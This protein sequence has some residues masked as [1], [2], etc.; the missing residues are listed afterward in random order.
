MICVL[1]NRKDFFFWH[2][3]IGAIVFR[4][5][6]KYW[7]C[8][9]HA[10]DEFGLDRYER[11]KAKKHKARR[12]KSSFPREIFD[13]ENSHPQSCDIIS[14]D[15]GF[16]ANASNVSALMENVVTPVN[17][18]RRRGPDDGLE[19]QISTSS[20]S[21][22]SFKTGDDEECQEHVEP[23][24]LYKV[25]LKDDVS[26]KSAQSTESRWDADI[27]RDID[28][29]E[30]KAA[31]RRRMQTKPALWSLM[32]LDNTGKRY[33]EETRE[34][35]IKLYQGEKEIDIPK[36]QIL[37]LK[38]NFYVRVAIIM[39]QLC[40]IVFPL[41]FFGCL[42]YLTRKWNLNWSLDVDKEDAGL[43][44]LSFLPVNEQLP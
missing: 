28:Y 13:T 34:K 43:P 36:D 35:L 22:E 24:V 30:M 41:A 19:Q 25:A 11:V 26:F 23:G 16:D 39:D 44:E 29:I 40:S 31:R 12:K 14:N 4:R 5:K 9:G 38:R 3:H 18:R 17:L 2:L 37:M 27:S 1:V 33:Y 15:I 20:I 6:L 8:G 42:I 32:T 21:R 7:F 10:Q